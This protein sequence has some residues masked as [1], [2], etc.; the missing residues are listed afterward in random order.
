MVRAKIGDTVRVHYTAKL[1]RGVIIDASEKDAP[2][3]FRIGEGKVIPGFEEAVIGMS[4]GEVKTV[5]IPPEKGYGVY[6]QD[7]EVEVDRSSLPEGIDPKIGEVL[8]VVEDDGRVIKVEVMDIIGDKIVLNANHP[9]AGVDL[10]YEIK[11]LEI[12]GTND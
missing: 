12:V 8:E 4:P 7:L 9:L 2:F 5:K 6:R 11:L 1:E 3:E 10:I